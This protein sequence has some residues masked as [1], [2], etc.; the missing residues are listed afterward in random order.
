MCFIRHNFIFLLTSSGCVAYITYTIGYAWAVCVLCV[1]CVCI[2]QMCT[3]SNEGEF[4]M[5]L[6]EASEAIRREHI[7]SEI[8][9]ATYH[10]ALVFETVFFYIHLH[11][12]YLLFVYICLSVSKER[13]KE[14]DVPCYLARVMRFLRHFKIMYRY[15]IWLF[16]R[17]HRQ[18]VI[19][20]CV[21]ECVRACVFFKALAPP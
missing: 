1:H 17:H 9:C 11:T 7:R 6:L 19:D 12:T 3:H 15:Y 4:R 21:C 20:V 2:M 16:N 13:S 14:F 5:E 8:S 18:G 10:F